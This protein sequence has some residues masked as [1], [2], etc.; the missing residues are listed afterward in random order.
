MGG[1]DAEHQDNRSQRYNTIS[2][3]RQSQ[4]RNQSF[5]FDTQGA[6]V[7]AVMEADPGLTLVP[8]WRIDSIPAAT[9]TS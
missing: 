2:Q 7:Q 6:F 9:P 1:L 8:A 4:T 5:E 3:V